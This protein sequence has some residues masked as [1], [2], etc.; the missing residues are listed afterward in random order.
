MDIPTGF[1]ILEINSP[2]TK[3]AGPLYIKEDALPPVLGMRIEKQHTNARGIAHGSALLLLADVA[4]GLSVHLFKEP[5][6]PVATSTLSAD[7]ASSAHLGDWVEARVDVQKV[8]SSMAYA[9]TYLSV[10]NKRL[11]RVS[12]TFNLNTQGH[13]G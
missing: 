8:G 3:H 11:V 2:F 9:N 12:A 1:K 6:V 13:Q 7:F 10:R 5:H 4:L